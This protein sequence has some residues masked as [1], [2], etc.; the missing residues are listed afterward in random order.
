MLRIEAWITARAQRNS[1]AAEAAE[2]T[3]KPA[4]APKPAA[5]RPQ[6][7]APRPRRVIKPAE[8][9]Y[10]PILEN[11]EDVE[12]YLALLRKTLEAALEAGARI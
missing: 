10:K 9:T 5:P 3:T 12:V 7:P 1:Q 2:T 6:K 8:L 11:R 4:A